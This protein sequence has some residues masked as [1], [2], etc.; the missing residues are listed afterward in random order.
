[1]AFKVFHQSLGKRLM[2]GVEIKAS[3]ASSGATTSSARPLPI[4]L[5]AEVMIKS[6]LPVSYPLLWAR[7]DFRAIECYAL[8]CT[9]SARMPNE[10][11]A[12]QVIQFM[13]GV[14]N[15]QTR[16]RGDDY[17]TT[18]GAKEGRLRK[19]KAYLKAKNLF[20]R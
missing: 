6:G 14:S 2:P 8:D 10:Q 13:R 18:W 5:G 1:M 4:R 7:L 15:G 9:Y 19:I 12:L 20:G 11:T 17:Q 16:N 3:P